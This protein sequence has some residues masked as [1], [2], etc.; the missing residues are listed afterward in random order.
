MGV[1]GNYRKPNMQDRMM[2]IEASYVP[3]EVCSYN[4][5]VAKS[6]E[7]KIRQ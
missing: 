2:E 6:L 3:K 7:G 5:N 1:N 4:E